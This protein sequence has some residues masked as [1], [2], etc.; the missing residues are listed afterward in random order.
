MGASRSRTGFAVLAGATVIAATVAAIPQAFADTPTTT[1][2]YRVTYSGGITSVAADQAGSEQLIRDRFARWKDAYVTADGA[3]GGRRV[4]SR[5][6]CAGAGQ[7]DTVSEAQGYGALLSVFLDDRQLF[8]DLWRYTRAHLNDDGLMGWCITPGGVFAEDAGGD[9]AATDADEDIAVAL[10]FA[11][12]KW[13]SD[14]GVDYAA[15]ARSQVQA[16]WEHCVERGTN[17]IKDGNYPGGAAATNPSYFAPAWYRIF[18]KFSGNAGWND[19]AAASYATVANIQKYDNGTGLVPEDVKGDGTAVPG[20][21]YDFQYNAFRYGWRTVIDDLWFG[22]AQAKANADRQN[23]FFRRIGAAAVVDHYTIDGTKVGTWGGEAVKSMVAAA[24]MTG[25][26]T[27]AARDFYEEAARTVD[28]TSFG[29]YGNS[30][31]LLSL[32][33][34]TGNFPDLSQSS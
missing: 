5:T 25:T 21:S 9:G 27:A 8:D 12:R 29:Y 33:L 7:A 28:D 10:I 34:M 32:L 24:F 23:A 2:P 22:T 31:G 26:D 4:V 18:A 13:G 19:V 17:L 11:D 15:A 6:G 1:F 16:L 20:K 3:G 30:L 14:D